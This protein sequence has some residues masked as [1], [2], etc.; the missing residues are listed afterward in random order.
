MVGP[1]VEDYVVDRQNVMVSHD[2]LREKEHERGEELNTLTD[3]VVYDATPSYLP[4][5]FRVTCHVNLDS[6]T[7]SDPNLL[8]PGDRAS[9]DIPI[10]SEV[11]AAKVR[12]HIRKLA[13]FFA[14]ILPACFVIPFDGVFEGALGLFH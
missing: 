9:V 5:T 10:V 7:D 8:L 1:P 13:S 6:A 12:G 14:S 4:S 3:F 2:H 11:Q